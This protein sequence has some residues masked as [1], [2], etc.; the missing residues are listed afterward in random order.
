MAP[1]V[2]ILVNST[3]SYYYI[4]PF[5]FG[6]L[7]RYGG[8]LNW[9]IYLG[10]EMADHPICKQ[11]GENFGVELVRIPSAFAGFIDSRWYCLTYLQGKH[12]YVLPLQDDFILEMPARLDAL[13]EILELMETNSEI[14][15]VRLMPCPGPAKGTAL[16]KDTELR[17]LSSKT[18]TYGFTYQATIWRWEDCLVWFQLLAD[19][20]QTAA[21]REFTD[22]KQRVRLEVGANIAENADGQRKFWELSEALKWHH[23]AWE[24]VGPWPNA[25]YLSPFPYRPTA[26]VRGALEGWAKELAKR[27]GFAL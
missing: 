7:Q 15:S 5:F 26:I 23:L 8:N 20:L 1:N 3:P 10:T 27:E 4:L 24:R 2:A 11:V 18:D 6:M 12:D 14:A 21:P 13:S 17:E 19:R 22:P 9:K 16:Y 25:V